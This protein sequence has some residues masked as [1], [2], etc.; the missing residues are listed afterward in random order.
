MN[1]YKKSSGNVSPRIPKCEQVEPNFWQLKDLCNISISLRGSRKDMG[2]LIGLSQGESPKSQQGLSGNHHGSSENSNWK[3][4]VLGLCLSHCGLL[5][6]VCWKVWRVW[7]SLICINSYNKTTEYLCQKK[8][9][10][11]ELEINTKLHRTWEIKARKIKGLH[12]SEEGEQ[13]QKITESMRLYFSKTVTTKS[14]GF[15]FW[16]W[17]TCPPFTSWTWYKRQMFSDIEQ[18][19]AGV[20]F[21]SKEKHMK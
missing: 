20:L 10:Q 2:S 7:S 18:Q 4:E 6:A 9:T 21:L 13:S 1:I 17:W 5:R 12:K 14:E 19:A 16:P 11:I 15:W 8:K 3:W